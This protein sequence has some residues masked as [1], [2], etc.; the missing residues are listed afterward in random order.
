[1]PLAPCRPRQLQYQLFRGSQARADGVLTTT[2]LRS[3]AWVR[4][5]R[6]LYADARLERDHELAC[7]AVA[8]RLP[9]YVAFAGPS[10]A[11]LLGVTHAAD[12]RDPVHVVVPADLRLG[13]ANGLIVHRVQLGPDDVEAAGDLRR[14]S[15]NR[16]VWDLACWLDPVRSVPTIDALLAQG[17]VS[18]ERL[19]QTIADRQPG[20]GRVRVRRTVEL[21]DGRAQSPQES[22][23]RVRLVQAGLPRPEAQYEVRIGSL[24]LHPDLAWP[25]Y[26]VALEYDGRWHDERQPF[27]RDRR[28]LR[29]FAGASWLVVPVTSEAVRYDFPGVVRDVRN[30]L[31]SRGAPL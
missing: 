16:T 19:H 29:S 25:E 9:E 1:M 12:F 6:D 20:R 26:R 17:L 4:V 15:P 23:L 24:I 18:V 14:T 11:A 13:N 7:R 30:A 31:R 27:H 8:L 10:A 5:G 22:R 28:R 21:A 3:S 2:Q